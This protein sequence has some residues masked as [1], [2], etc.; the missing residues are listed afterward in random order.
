MASRNAAVC[1]RRSS[2]SRSTPPVLLGVAF[3]VRVVGPDGKSESTVVV[4]VGGG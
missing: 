2:A 1:W 3:D 4:E